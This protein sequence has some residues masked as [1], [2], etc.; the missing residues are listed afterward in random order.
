M[1]A[2]APGFAP[3]AMRAIVRAALRIIAEPDLAPLFTETARAEVSLS[4]RVIVDGV[5]RAV[6]GRVDRLAVEADIVRIADFKTGRP[7]GEGEPLPP[8]DAGQIALYARVL[9][10]VYP[11]RTVRAML[12]WTSGPVIRTLTAAEQ[13]AALARA[14]ILST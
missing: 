12:V 11:G 10:Q 3:P 7:P 8:F 14:G 9:A 5:E 6:Q 13:D 2:R 1:R 4:G